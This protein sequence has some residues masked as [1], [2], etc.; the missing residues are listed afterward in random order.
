MGILRDD[1]GFDIL[2]NGV[3]RTF[4]DIE[5]NAYEAARFAKKWHKGDLVELRK[6]ATGQKIVFLENGRTG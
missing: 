1:E 6:R 4:R 2:I 3:W 5:A